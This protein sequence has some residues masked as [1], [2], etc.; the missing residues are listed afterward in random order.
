MENWKNKKCLK[1]P[2]RSGDFLHF[3][4]AKSPVFSM[5]Q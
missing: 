5:N 1:P 4:M 2:T 3:A